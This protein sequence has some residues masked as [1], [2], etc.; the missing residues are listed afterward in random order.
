MKR[1]S[2]YCLPVLCAVMSPMFADNAGNQSKQAPQQM[3]EITP[4]A[5]PLVK[6]S[7][8]PFL[9]A[10]Y[11]Y[12]RANQEGTDYAVTGIAPGFASFS[13]KGKVHQPSF[14]YSSG[15]K[16]GFGLKFRHDSWDMLAN[17]TWLF[18]DDNHNT[19]TR[20]STQSMQ[21][22]WEIAEDSTRLTPDFG[23][24][25]SKWAMHFNVLDLEMGRN[26]FISPRLTL[27]PHFG[28]KLAWIDQDMTVKY[29]NGTSA[30]E[31]TVTAPNEFTYKFD[32]DK[33]GV[34]IRAGF[35]TAWFMWNKWSVFGNFA[36]TAL[37]SDFDVDQKLDFQS[38]GTG[39]VKM[40]DLDRD[41]H[42]VTPVLEFALG[43]RYETDFYNNNYQ[44]MIQAGWEEQIWF[45]ENQFSNLS[46]GATGNLTIEGLTIKTGFSF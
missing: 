22:T 12:W 41:V 18:S 30:A 27:R 13:G 43:L 38:A 40:M 42:T 25:H 15:F 28:L 20:K 11:I 29:K 1:F 24:A 46:N 35:N 10:E 8:D 31:P 44:F 4:P 9:T 5:Y 26:Y 37:Y 23:S 21:N 34:G 16:V 2:L 3:A 33:F 7:A 17:Y 6:R 32:Q 14:D 19:T 39:K 36:A 45:N